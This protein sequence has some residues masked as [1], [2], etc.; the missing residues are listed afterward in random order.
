MT[1]FDGVALKPTL[2]P[3]MHGVLSWVALIANSLVA[4]DKCRDERLAREGKPPS[5]LDEVMQQS[6]L[7]IPGI[8]EALVQLMGGTEEA[9]QAA[10]LIVSTP[11]PAKLLRQFAEQFGV[12][13]DPA[14]QASAAPAPST[15]APSP[16]ASSPELGLPKF[17]ADFTREGREAT[18]VG[19]DAGTASLPKFR[20]DFTREGREAAT[21]APSPSPARET[22]VGPT[23][24]AP[25]G[26]AVSPVE[27][28]RPS[29]V[30]MV[31]RQLG[32]LRR[33]MKAHEAEFD[34]RLK[35]AEAELAALREQFHQLV[36]G[37][38]KPVL[39]VVPPQVDEPTSPLVPIEEPAAPE[40]AAASTETPVSA[41]P[42]VSPP[43]AAELL[44]ELAEPLPAAATEEEVVRAV[45]MIGAFSEEVEAQHEHNVARLAEVEHEISVMRALVE[46][47]AGEAATIHG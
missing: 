33:R 10:S 45:E 17:R 3:T 18:K 43:D 9:K 29:L 15:A 11:D 27:P 21:A 31:E 16:T 47:E 36:A 1:I 26:V 37:K 12:R 5:T 6:G 14:P 41:E 23:A 39:F 8:E 30:E 38:Q 2:S 46:R 7:H 34:A 13:V 22:N 4:A 20:T 25:T 19:A 35:R 40:A 32:A 28:A 44:A 24:A 42:P